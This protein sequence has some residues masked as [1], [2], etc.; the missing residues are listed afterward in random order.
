MGLPAISFVEILRTSCAWNRAC[1]LGEQVKA[2]TT[3]FIRRNIRLY[4]SGA[5]KGSTRLERQ[6]GLVDALDVLER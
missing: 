5:V 3:S 1:S 4:L 2:S 6:D